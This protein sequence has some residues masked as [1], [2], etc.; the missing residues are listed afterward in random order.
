MLDEAPE[1]VTGW[2][3]QHI[4]AG[5]PLKGRV[6][7]D[8]AVALWLRDIHRSKRWDALTRTRV[9]HGPLGAVREFRYLDIVDEISNEDLTQGPRTSVTD[10]FRRAAERIRTA[11]EGALKDDHKVLCGPLPVPL[12]RRGMVLLRTGAQLVE[13]GRAL[14]HCVAGYADHVTKGLCWILAIRDRRGRSTVE[15]DRSL[16][17]RQ[18]HGAQNRLPP[19]FHVWLLQAWMN[20]HQRKGR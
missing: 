19:K 7:R 3:T 17:V 15:L 6:V 10:A 18:H 1:D 8:P 11:V 16:Q 13:E 9:A 5:L 20:R 2:K 12:A 14:G 4:I